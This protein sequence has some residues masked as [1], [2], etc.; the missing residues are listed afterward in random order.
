MSV[1]TI[2]PV[3]LKEIQYNFAK[4]LDTKIG[5]TDRYVRD[6]D[7]LQDAEEWSL[8]DYAGAA[9]GFQREY[10]DRAS[11]EPYWQRHGSI[12]ELPLDRSDRRADYAVDFDSSSAEIRQTPEGK[13]AMYL[14]FVQGYRDRT[15][16]AVGVNGWFFASE[17]GTDKPYEA[18]WVIRTGD[19]TPAGCQLW[20][21]VLG[22][23]YGYLDGTRVEYSWH[24]ITN[25]QPNTEYTWHDEFAI[26]KNYRHCLVNFTLWMPGYGR[27]EEMDGWIHSCT[28]KRKT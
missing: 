27:V 23:R 22:Y 10:M 16:G 17:V 28:V 8:L 11:G 4:P 19:N 7:A 26:N 6:F 5:S 25:A 20:G 24:N 14:H 3:S 21:M 18:D 12:Y 2:P 13:N 1:N 15:P 9:F